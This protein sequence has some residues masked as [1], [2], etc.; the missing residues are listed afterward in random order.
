MSDLSD[1]VGLSIKLKVSIF[2]SLHKTNCSAPEAAFLASRSSR[3]GCLWP[4]PLQ[5]ALHHHH[6]SDNRLGLSTPVRQTIDVH[7]LDITEQAG[8]PTTDSSRI[9]DPPT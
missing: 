6:L 8:I 7:A 5:R 2:N 3:F 4:L 9:D 1:T